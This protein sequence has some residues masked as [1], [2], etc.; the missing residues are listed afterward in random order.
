MTSNIRSLSSPSHPI[1][2][3]FGE[4]PTKAQVALGDSSEVV[5]KDFVLNVKL[6]QPHQYVVYISLSLSLSLTN[7]I[8]FILDLVAKFKRTRRVIWLPW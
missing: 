6:A 7:K 4:E 5:T 1:S 3:E 8:I 2:F